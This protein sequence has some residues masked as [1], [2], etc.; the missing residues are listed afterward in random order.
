MSLGIG[1][2]SADRK[3]DTSSIPNS[4]LSGGGPGFNLLIGGTPSPGFALGGGLLWNGVH[5]PEA[6]VGESTFDT[7]DVDIATSM[8]GVFID[9][10]PDPEGGLHIG[11]ML[12]L[13]GFEV[14]ADNDALDEQTG[15]LG[16]AAWIGYGGWV[17][18]DWSLGGML[19]LTAAGTR[20]DFTHSDGS[21]VVEEVG[22]GT[23][24]ILFTALYH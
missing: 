5:N 20:R 6:E 11:G 16:A 7:E 19:Q 23:L 15:G 3:Y 14:A 1:G 9:G 8:L 10:F 18:S 2:L 12:G 24:S 21:E 17:G 22:V 13:V 4:K